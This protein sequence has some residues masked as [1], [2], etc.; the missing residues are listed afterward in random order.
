MEGVEKRIQSLRQQINEHNHKYHVLDAPVIPD[1]EYDRLFH[2]LA[3]LETRY[4]EYTTSDSPTQRVGAGP[5]QQFSEVAHEMPMLSLNNAFGE[6][7]MNAFDRR[8]REK[9]CK[10]DIVYTA[11]TK[12]D[13]LAISIL[14]ENGRLIRAATRGDG[15]RGEN[16][17]ANVRTI[18]TVPIVLL[19]QD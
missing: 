6:T 11:E 8:V 19:G 15:N 16:V 4:P 2:E 13:G 9:L 17:T 3:E 1:A 18:R 14:Y 10:E 5:L 7:D 12:L